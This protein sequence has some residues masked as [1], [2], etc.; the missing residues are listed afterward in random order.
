MLYPA[1]ANATVTM[2]RCNGGINRDRSEK[3]VRGELVRMLAD[4]CDLAFDLPAIDR[5]LAGLNDDDLLTIVDGEESE[6]LTLL[7]TAPAG[8]DQLLNRIFEQVS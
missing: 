7:T 8:T 5:W 4:G 1:I 2:S 6:A 3:V